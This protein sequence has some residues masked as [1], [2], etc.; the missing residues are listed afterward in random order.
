MIQYTFIYK[1]QLNDLHYNAVNILKRLI[2]RMWNIR[3]FAMTTYDL[4]LQL[5]HG[6]IYC[7][8]TLC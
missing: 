4:V 7:N 3:Q 2:D 5:M 1:G 8:G 6:N